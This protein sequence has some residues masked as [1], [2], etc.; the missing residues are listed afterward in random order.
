MGAYGLVSR[1]RTDLLGPGW[2]PGRLLP[3]AIVIALSAFALEVYGVGVGAYTYGDWP[4]KVWGV[5]PGILVV[6]VLVGG[7]SW[8]VGMRRG[9]IAGVA[10]GVALDTFVL[11]PLAYHFHLWWWTSSFTP[12]LGY[13]GTVGNI[14]AWAGVCALSFLV[15]RRVEGAPAGRRGVAALV[16]GTMALLRG[17]ERRP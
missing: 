12:H 6:W 1:V 8:W 10:T 7:L 17:S 4:V 16:A 2:G 14:V 11:E 15:L 9:A 5:P 3:G 13:F